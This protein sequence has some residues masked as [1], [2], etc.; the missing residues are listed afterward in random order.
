MAETKKVLIAE[1][2]SVI[3]NLT[4]KIL[5]MQNY[6]IHSAKN[7]E[8]VLKALESD[9]FDIILM[10]INMPKMDGMECTRAIRALND[11][12][13]S[14]IPII[15][16]TGNAKNYSIEDFKEA[17]INEYLQKPLNFDQLV[18]TVKKLTN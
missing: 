12:S 10:D 1:D 16:I 4:K 2:S 5:M 13:K 17:G 11:K 6:S 14:S 9:T 7:G 3:Q 15:A 8:Q 18:E